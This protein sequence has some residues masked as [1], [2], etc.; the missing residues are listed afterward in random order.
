MMRS[1]KIT[2]PIPTLEEFGKRLGISKARQK[3]LKRIIMG[4]VNG[5]ALTTPEIR[6]GATLS[7]TAINKTR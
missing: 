5:K 7:G 3:A 6:K 2:T 4:G 1:A